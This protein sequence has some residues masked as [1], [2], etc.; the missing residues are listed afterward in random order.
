MNRLTDSEVA[1][2]R[3][4]LRHA[5]YRVDTVDE[6]LGPVAHAALGRG[7]RVPALRATTG[8]SPLETLVRL[9]LAGADEPE[10][11]V[12]AALPLE[13]CYAGNLVEP[14]GTGL[15]AAVDLRPYHDWWV[16]SDVGARWR[17]GPLRCDHVLGV[18][19]ASVT[20]AQATVPVPGGAA[21][22]LGVGSGVQSLHLCQHA[23]TVTGTDV[24]P[25]AL[26][27]ADLT[28]RLNGIGWELLPGSLFEPVAG[29]RFDLIVS[30][31]PFVLGPGD[32][33]AYRSAGSRDGELCR[34][35]ARRAPG[36]L[37]PGG[38]CQFLANWTHL[39]GR[40]WQEQVTSW[41]DGTGCDAWVWQREVQDPAEYAG[42]WLRDSHEDTNPD[43]ERRY[44]E[45]LDWMDGHEVEAVGFGMVTMR[46]A[47]AAD[48]VVRV[49]EVRQQVVQPVAG[50]IADWF[51]RQDRLRAVP[52]LLD[53]RLRVA[54]D[55]VL[56]QVASPAGGWQVD[57]QR[58]HL[59]SGMRWQ[60]EVD[61]LAASLVAGCD[62]V[63]R[64]RDQLA[65]LAAA[66]GYRQDDLAGTALP[67]VR[68][69]VERGFLLFD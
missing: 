18:G 68:H 41:F 24:N 34:R 62:G 67:V 19:G 54:P 60:G 57:V 49:E 45:W 26:H 2:L 21:L 52:D 16:A 25:R 37:A 56:E 39:R 17:P 7:E 8:G 15:R 9:F 6:L 27:L 44:A 30:N 50:P 46:A 14:H 29:R 43:H 48:P 20:L 4:A 58:L 23:A 36:L 11:A 51:G 69:L 63:V 13:V 40:P 12:A 53:A 28:A 65:L 22:D 33:Y 64:L 55:V 5:D 61:Q 66:Y 32:D 47:G 59:T 38:W 42:M 1:R 3:D 10:A 31:P 35:I